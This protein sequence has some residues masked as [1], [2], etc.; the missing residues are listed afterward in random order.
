MSARGFCKT[1]NTG[2]NMHL[3]N[4]A[5]DLCCFVKKK[6]CIFLLLVLLILPTPLPVLPS[7]A[8][9]H[10]TFPERSIYHLRVAF[11]GSS[12]LIQRLQL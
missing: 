5:H 4:E 10:V 3:L 6:V 12:V 7:D 2:L 1:A 8:C 9:S 11:A